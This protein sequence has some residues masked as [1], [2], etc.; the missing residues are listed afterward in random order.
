MSEDEHN[1]FRA[2]QLIRLSHQRLLISQQVAQASMDCL[3]K[4]QETV[5]RSRKLIQQSDA[6]I[7]LLQRPDRSGPRN[8]P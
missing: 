3:N 1:S 6:L 2:R 4:T 8:L 7:A 5:R